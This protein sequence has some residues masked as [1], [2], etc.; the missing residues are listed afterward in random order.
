[1]SETQE[2]RDRRFEEERKSAIE[3][4]NA[5]KR[6]IGEHLV[7]ATDRLFEEICAGESLPNDKG[8]N[9]DALIEIGLLL[10]RVRWE[11]GLLNDSVDMVPIPEPEPTP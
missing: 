10:W 5:I 6:R 8:V 3:A 9:S 4:D 7:R 11:L 1:M 2:E